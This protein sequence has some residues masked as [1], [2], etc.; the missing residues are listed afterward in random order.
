MTGLLYF[1]IIVSLSHPVCSN[2]G[3]G[4]CCGCFGGNAVTVVW[5]F[6]DKP[7]DVAVAVGQDELAAFLTQGLLPVSQIVANKFRTVHTEGNEAVAWPTRS[8]KKRK[9]YLT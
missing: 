4:E 3:D 7:E 1:I 5:A 6:A 9:L 2:H 8:Q